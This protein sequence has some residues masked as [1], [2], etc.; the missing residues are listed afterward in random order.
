MILFINLTPLI[1]LSLTRRGRR[2]F[3]EEAKPPLLSSLPLP[4]IKEGGQG[5]RLLHKAKAGSLKN[6]GFFRVLRE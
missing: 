3:R 2:G 6:Q 5:D 4:L 1:S